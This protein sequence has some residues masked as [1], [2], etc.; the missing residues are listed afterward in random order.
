MMFRFWIFGDDGGMKWLIGFVVA[1]L[2]SDAVHAQNYEPGNWQSL[3]LRENYVEDRKA[4]EAENSK[5]IIDSFVQNFWNRPVEP[6]N[7]DPQTSLIAS[8]EHREARHVI[9]LGAS[10]PNWC[11]GPFRRGLSFSASA[12]TRMLNG[13]NANSYEFGAALY[14]KNDQ[15]QCVV[16]SRN[17]DEAAYSSDIRVPSVSA[18]A[19][20]YKMRQ[21]GIKLEHC[22]LRH[23]GNFV[24]DLRKLNVV[25]CYLENHGFD[26]KQSAQME[27]VYPTISIATYGNNF[28]GIKVHDASFTDADVGKTWSQVYSEYQTD[29]AKKRELAKYKD[30]HIFRTR[31]QNEKTPSEYYRHLGVLYSQSAFQKGGFVNGNGGRIIDQSDVLNARSGGIH[32]SSTAPALTLAERNQLIADDN[33]YKADNA[34][35]QK[36][37][38][39]LFEKYAPQDTL[40]GWSTGNSGPDAALILH[41]LYSKGYLKKRQRLGKDAFTAQYYLRLA[42]DLGSPVAHDML[43]VLESK[44]GIGKPNA[45]PANIARQYTHLSES[46]RLSE[47]IANSRYVAIKNSDK[48]STV[49][50]RNLADLWQWAMKYDIETGNGRTPKLMSKQ[51]ANFVGNP[52]QKCEK[53]DAYISESSIGYTD[54]NIRLFLSTCARVASNHVE[55]MGYFNRYYPKHYR[56]RQDAR[57]DKGKVLM[58]ISNRLS[59]FG[60]DAAMKGAIKVFDIRMSNARIV[61]QNRQKWA[62]EEARWAQQRRES[63]ARQAEW[64]AEMAA[65]EQAEEDRREAG[66]KRQREKQARWDAQHGGSQSTGQMI[67]DAMGN[68]IRS[69]P[70]IDQMANDANRRIVAS[71]RQATANRRAEQQRMAAAQAQRNQAA[72][73][74]RQQR[75][76]QQRA[77]QQMAVRRNSAR[78]QSRSIPNAERVTSS[79]SKGV[80]GS[81]VTCYKA[82]TTSTIA[83]SIV[84]QELERRASHW[85]SVRDQINKSD[86]KGKAPLEYVWGAIPRE[87]KTGFNGRNWSRVYVL[88]ERI[89]YFD[90]TTCQNGDLYYSSP[91]GAIRGFIEKA[92]SR[93]RNDPGTKLPADWREH[94]VRYN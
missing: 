53:I 39:R 66:R 16:T 30:R 57:D 13:K 21:R 32:A 25:D 29:K 18:Q 6:V 2:F 71:Q 52:T 75:L 50:R 87:I 61:A 22:D 89:E 67:S 12:P 33:A 86:F 80:T 44:T 24:S 91:E 79:P 68:I 9:Q 23:R 1:G 38:Q 11:D 27:N 49:L 58:D 60:N 54:S 43:Y 88:I 74:A 72:E 73:R 10:V 45:T 70:T 37:Y 94:V 20:L 4:M 51:T 26:N 19:I 34:S 92:N 28:L 76:A 65:K 47:P 64:K 81:T 15:G 55:V 93:T 63:A 3:S 31:P 41:N 7:R 90:G 69:R 17:F 46:V 42:A 48:A 78:Q 62:A 77:A 14:K 40:Y 83:P 8:V 56:I 82:T 85:A 84:R 5:L 59:R 35:N 36:V